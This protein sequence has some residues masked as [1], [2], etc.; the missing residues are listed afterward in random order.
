MR[1][2]E[3]VF[4]IQPDLDET[5]VKGLVDKVQGWITEAGGTVAKVDNWGKRRLAYQINKRRE[6]QY[7]LFELQLPPTASA[8]LERNLR[9][10]EP[11]MRFSIIHR[12]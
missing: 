4:I 1:N 5:A 9:F 3:L 12:D 10:Q 11:I 2:Y 6:G 7:V 8:E